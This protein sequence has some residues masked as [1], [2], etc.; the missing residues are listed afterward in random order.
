MRLNSE[1]E[2]VE[3]AR[4]FKV[5]TRTWRR[6][7]DTLDPSY[8]NAGLIP[9]IAQIFHC[10][11]DDLFKHEPDWLPQILE[12]RELLRAIRKGGQQA[13][14]RLMASTLNLALKTLNDGDMA[15][16][17]DIGRRLSTRK[18]K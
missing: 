17:V 3:F 15:A 1:I 9:Q 16:W 6:W 11:T 10:S 12:E 13:F 7:E 2:Q 14:V 8:P 18:M 4:T 5:S